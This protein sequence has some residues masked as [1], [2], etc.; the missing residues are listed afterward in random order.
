MPQT[1]SE[2][3][4]ADESDSDESMDGGHPAKKPKTS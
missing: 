4:T 2:E 3:E 1:S